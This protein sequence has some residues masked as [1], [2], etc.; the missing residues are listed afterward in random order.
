MIAIAPLQ[1]I[2]L[3][4]GLILVYDVYILYLIVVPFALYIMHKYIYG[5]AV[6]VL[7]LVKF[8]ITTMNELLLINN[9]EAQIPLALDS[10]PCRFPVTQ[11]QKQT[12]KKNRENISSNVIFTAKLLFI[13]HMRIIYL[14]A[15]YMH[16]RRFSCH[17]CVTVLVM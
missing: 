2:V 9:Y 5:C 13:M 15:S 4:A 14:D 17:I 10:I 16:R 7:Q 11:K 12:Q 6:A 1:R 3:S 8:Q